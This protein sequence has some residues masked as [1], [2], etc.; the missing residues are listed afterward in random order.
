MKELEPT[1]RAIAA[2][3]IGYALACI[4]SFASESGTTLNVIHEAQAKLRTAA[5]I[6]CKNWLDSLDVRN[7]TIT[8]NIERVLREAGDK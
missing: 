1:E 4:D 2:D 7:E 6:L 8:Q 5:L 3:A